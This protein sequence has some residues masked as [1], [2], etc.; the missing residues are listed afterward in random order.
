MQVKEQA[1]TQLVNLELLKRG[2]E[3]SLYQNLKDRGHHI[4]VQAD[5]FCVSKS[6]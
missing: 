2:N 4:T 6:W 1:E 3:L 5:I